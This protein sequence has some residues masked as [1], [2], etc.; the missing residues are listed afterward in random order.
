MATELLSGLRF[1]LIP[2]LNNTFNGAFPAPGTYLST[3]WVFAVAF[4]P[5]MV[6][7]KVIL[8][9]PDDQFRDSLFG[10]L[11]F[12]TR[13]NVLKQLNLLTP[14]LSLIVSRN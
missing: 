5:L 1:F 11:N 12:K 3:L 2:I 9:A 14:T 6:S 10:R 4:Q 7:Q 8:L 13:P